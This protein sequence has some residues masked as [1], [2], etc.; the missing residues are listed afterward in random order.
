[1]KILFSFLIVNI[2]VLFSGCADRNAFMAFHLTKEQELSEDSILTLKLKDKTSIHGTI[3][4]VYLNK[5]FPK[6]FHDK[7]SFYIYYYL[8]DKNETISFLLNGKKPLSIEKLSAENRYADLT[9]FKAPWSRYEVV[10][11]PKEGNVLKLEVKTDK[12]ADA[13][14]KFVKDK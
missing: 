10:T 14:L 6:E 9:D 13:A 12:A 5:V 4:V 8:K 3:S 2:L 1:M 7:E 11:F